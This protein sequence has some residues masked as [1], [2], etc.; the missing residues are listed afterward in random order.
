METQSSITTVG[1]I[2]RQWRKIRRYSQLDLASAADVSPR[3]LSFIE[4]GRSKASY[5]L[6][7]RLANV[8]Q[9]PLRHANMLL[10]AGGYAQRY[11]H[12][13]LED[14]QTGSVK[15]ALHYMMTQS[16]PYPAIVTNQTYDI[17]M[18]NEGFQRLIEWLMGNKNLI[19]KYINGYR[20]IFE[21]D[22]LK[23]FIVNWDDVQ[24]LFLKR[25]HDESI[26]YQNKT[27]QQLYAEYSHHQMQDYIDSN[28]QIPVLTLSL[29]KD[30]IT[31]ELMSI[32]SVFGTA[33]DI[34]VQ[35][36]RIET[37]FPA[38]EETQKIFQS[39]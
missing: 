23:Q 3:H 10:A 28:Y 7:I 26:A 35:E 21:D 37:F 22:G 2:L 29:E 18:M 34:T 30:G 33:I 9:L 25:L 13:A 39:L 6:L 14:D 8:L 17:L 31:L 1:D 19:A 32:L 27:L 11:T 38:N 5:E 36:L 4:T 20:L 15:Q 16:N 24:T 12:W